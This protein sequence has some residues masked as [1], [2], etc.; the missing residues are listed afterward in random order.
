MHLQCIETHELQKTI[1]FPKLLLPKKRIEINNKTTA[2]SSRELNA[3]RSNKRP[4]TSDNSIL[5][6]T[7]SPQSPFIGSFIA[8]TRSTFPSP[9]STYRAL[10]PY[11]SFMTTRVPHPVDLAHSGR[12]VEMLATEGGAHKRNSLKS[13]ARSPCIV[14]GRGATVSLETSRESEPSSTIVC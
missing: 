8:V 12:A 6:P 9:S 1:R 5:P 3:R 10:T 14:T 11:Q 13:T 4:K 2:H 7:N